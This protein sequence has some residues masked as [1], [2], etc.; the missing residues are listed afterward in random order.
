ML[1]E[2][3]QQ[4]DELLEILWHLDEIHELTLA[5]LRDHDPDDKFKSYLEGLVR[6]KAITIEGDKIRFTSDGKDFARGIIR[7]HRLAERLLSD[8]LGMKP[9]DTEKGACE[10]EHVLAREITDSICILLGHPRRCPHGAPIPEG[11]C[12]SEARNQVE[13]AVIPVTRVPIGIPARVAYINTTNEKRMHKLLNLGVTPGVTIRVHQSYP[14]F[15]LEINDAQIAM[16]TAVAEE[17]YVWKPAK[18]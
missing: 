2:T 5:T 16:E 1:T 11:K 10:F 7:R 12:C 3:E 6:K 17:I 9:E 8:V 4:E 14:A 15:V 18:S 13:G